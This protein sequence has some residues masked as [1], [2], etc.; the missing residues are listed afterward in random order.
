MKF[1]VENMTCGHCVRAVTNALQDADAQ[2]KVAVDL[3]Q[4]QVIVNSS[5]DSAKVIALLQEEGYPA[6]ILAE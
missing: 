2:A 5:L 1:S 4:K 3:Q 6:K